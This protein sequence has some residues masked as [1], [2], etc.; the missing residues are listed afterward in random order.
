VE[1]GA[2]VDGDLTTAEILAVR[3]QATEA[4][5]RLKS[6]DRYK[7]VYVLD[8]SV[9]ALMPLLRRADVRKL[10]LEIMGLGTFYY[11]EGIWKLYVVN[12]PLVFRSVYAVVAP[13][14]HPVTKNKIKILG[15]PKAYLAEMARAG[16][17]ATSVPAL[18]GGQHP[19]LPIR[20]VVLRQ[21]A[22]VEPSPASESQ[23]APEQQAPPP[24]HEETPASE[25]DAPQR[26][27]AATSSA[28]QPKKKKKKGGFFSCCAA[29]DD[30]D[31]AATTRFFSTEDDEV[32]RP[33]KTPPPA[34]DEAKQHRDVAPP[35]ETETRAPRPPPPEQPE[36]TSR[37]LVAAQ[38][39]RS[40][41]PLLA[42]AGGGL[43][44]V[45]FLVWF[46]FY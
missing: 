32:E 5:E 45:L 18:L 46:T 6:D 34:E 1:V 17:P 2:L 8:L 26:Q 20:D 13:F 42:K 4:M 30:V 27:A 38:Q 24:S 41:A 12:A 15:G 19:G 9:L 44:M 31:E 21:L 37:Q 36:D 40:L 3:A 33:Q 7:A 16:L 22:S 39:P 29:G 23:Q 43:S 25:E 10:T 14:I 11:P 28:P 35:P